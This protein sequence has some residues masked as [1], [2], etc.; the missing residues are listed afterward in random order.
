MYHCGMAHVQV[1]NAED[2]FKIWRMA[3]SKQL[4]TAGWCGGWIVYSW[5]VWGLDCVKLVGLGVG[6]CTA[7]RFGG[8][9]VYSWLVW[10]LDVAL[11][12][13]HCKMCSF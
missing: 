10:G 5:F 2:Y 9:I 8:W 1:V 3:M 6:L 7:G 12:V 13:L 4:C 11:T